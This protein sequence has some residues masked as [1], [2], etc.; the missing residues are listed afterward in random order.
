[1]YIYVHEFIYIFMN[2]YMCIYICSYAYIHTHI[3][4]FIHTYTY[5][6]TYIYIYIHVCIYIYTYIYIWVTSHIHTTVDC[7][8]A[9]TNSWLT[10]PVQTLSVGNTEMFFFWFD[11][12]MWC[13]C[14]TW[15]IHICDMTHRASG[16]G[17]CWQHR[18]AHR[19]RPLSNDCWHH[20]YL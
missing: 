13:V 18:G 12:S 5:I 2:I 15:L 9:V 19:H 20:Y 7:L 14:V 3:Y 8:C 1:M 16:D 4:I 17:E 10:E 6:H 11:S